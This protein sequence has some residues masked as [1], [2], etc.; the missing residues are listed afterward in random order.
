M[1]AGNKCVLVLWDVDHTLIENSGM[2]KATYALAFRK[3]TGRA[4]GT[5]PN[6]EGRTDREIMRNLFVANGIEVNLEQESELITSLIDASRELTPDLLARGYALAG[7][8]ESLHWLAEQPA[9]VQSVLTGNIRPNAENKLKL[10]GTVAGLLDLEVGG[11]GSDDTMRS[12]LV[13]VAQDKAGQKYG[14]VF[15]KSSTVLI[16]DTERDVGAAR[17][18]GAKIVAVATGVTSQDE[19]EQAGA[20]IVL[21]DLADVEALVRSITEL[22]GVPLGAPL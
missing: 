1:T 2:S 16:G 6:T 13:R 7:A 15:D 22:T 5:E 11:Y 3:L 12:R 10:L 21:R 20:D 9:V 4:P 17:D 8:I 19:L 18:G 14:T